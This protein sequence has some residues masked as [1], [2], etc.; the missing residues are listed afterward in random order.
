M[1]LYTFKH[2]DTQFKKSQPLNVKHFVIYKE[3]RDSK[4][5]EFWTNQNFE[6]LFKLHLNRMKMKQGKNLIWSCFASFL[7]EDQISKKRVCVSGLVYESRINLSN[8]SI[9]EFENWDVSSSQL[10]KFEDYTF[11]KIRKDW[12]YKFFDEEIKP[13]CN[14]PG[15]FKEDIR[16]FPRRGHF[17]E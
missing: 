2:L 14:N 11:L 8:G 12:I 4:D 6:N 7:D 9:F 15:D 3:F 13:K 17:I 1:T 16:V 5:I 10:Y